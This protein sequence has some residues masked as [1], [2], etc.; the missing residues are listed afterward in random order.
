MTIEEMRN[1]KKELGYSYEQLSGLTGIP[2]S[3]IQKIFGGTT[4]APRRST[5]A[6]LEGVLSGS[7]G[8]KGKTG[9]YG[10]SRYPESLLSSRGDIVMEPGVPYGTAARK[11]GGYTVDDYFRLPESRGRCEL[12]NGV[13]YDMSSPSSAHQAVSLRLAAGLLRFAD[14]NGGE[15]RVYTAPFDV[16]P[17]PADQHTVV[18][19]DV[20]IIC[21]PDKVRKG[22]CEGAPDLVVEILSPSTR[23]RDLI[24]KHT[25]YAEAGVREYWIV[26]L[27]AQVVVIY[28]F[29]H[30]ALPRICGF[31]TPVPVGIWEG[32]CLI[33]FG[34]MMKR[35]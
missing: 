24:L 13:I 4:R 31:D 33:D 12:I 20:M 18:Q 21:D 22:W 30:E 19:P 6:A 7:P 5:I 29:E 2:C 26:D 10:S 25:K 14:G 28:D 3:T 32:K 11:D 27:D 1:R 35:L 16:V 23:R 17:D 9:R 8:A 34:D 15:C